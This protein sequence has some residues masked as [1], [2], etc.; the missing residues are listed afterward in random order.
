MSYMSFN[1]IKSAPLWMDVFDTF[2]YDYC[3][4]DACILKTSEYLK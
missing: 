3:D 4:S 1:S 2:Y